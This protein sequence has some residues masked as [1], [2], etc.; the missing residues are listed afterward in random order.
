MF[1]G[2]YSVRKYIVTTVLATSFALAPIMSGS[3][4][5]Y[6]G[7]AADTSANQTSE[8]TQ[9]EENNAQEAV[10]AEETNAST[11]RPGDSGPAVSDLQSKLQNLGYS[12]NIDGIYG[13]NTGSAVRDLQG[14]SGIQIDGIAGPATFNALNQNP[15][16]ATPTNETVEENNAPEENDEDV[17]IQEAPQQQVKPQTLS[18]SGSGDAVSTAQSLVGTPYVWGGTTPAGFDSSGFVTYVLKQEGVNVGRTHADMWASGGQHVSNPSPGDV[19]F[20]EN[21]YKSGVSHSGIYVGNGQ[22]IHAGTEATG[23]EYANKND[24]YWGPRYIGAKSF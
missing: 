1:K 16:N 5:A 22:M 10:Q 2:K 21:T 20:F 9:V 14:N 18:L 4:L 23:V 6:G 11:L 17:T 24:S 15:S 19:V 7:P 3:V 12:L 13:E 8:T